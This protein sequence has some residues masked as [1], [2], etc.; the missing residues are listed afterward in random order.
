MTTLVSFATLQFTGGSPLSPANT[1]RLISYNP[2]F[3]TALVPIPGQVY[4]FDLYGLSA[5]PLKQ[6]PTM[7]WE[8]LLFSNNNANPWPDLESQ[9]NAIYTAMLGTYTYSGTPGV[10]GQVGNL[11]C[12]DAGGAQFTAF[13]R[14]LT[15][16]KPKIAPGEVA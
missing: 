11:V 16:G 8:Y 3:E 5:A 6:P 9:Y 1:S 4:P 10:S 12:A 2:E 15:P 13:A 7:A 14:A